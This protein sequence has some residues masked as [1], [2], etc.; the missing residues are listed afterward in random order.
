M[1]KNIAYFADGTWDDPS[2]NTN[3]LQLFEATDSIDGAQAKEYDSGIGADGNPVSHLFG[4]AFGAG[5]TGKIK[6]G[7]TWIAS[8]YLPGDLIYLFGFSRGAYTARCLAGMIAVS[9]LPTVNQ[10]DPKCLD[11]AFEAYRNTDYR[12]EILDE[13]NHSYEMDNAKIHMIGVWDTVGSLGIP[14]I[15]GGV[16]VIQ[17]GFLDTS[18]HPDVQNAVQALAIDEERLQF[19]P[20]L[21]APAQTPGQTLAQV[22]FTGCHCDVGGG[23]GTD[24]NGNALS[25]ITLR[26]M[27]GH[28]SNN[29]LQISA[30][31][32]PQT[33][34]IDDAMAAINNSLIGLYTLTPHR[35][36]IASDASLYVS[37]ADRC[38]NPSA[39]YSPENLHIRAG[40]LSATYSIVTIP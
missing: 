3:V 22:W 6:D 8:Q 12:S 33:P 19:Q 15:F 26:W 5:I 7:Y 37:V 4:G 16:D 23:N 38:G 28:A 17:Y 2:N 32:L 21:W 27:A 29:G 39:N 31:K 25:N 34:L 30:G 13:L 24:K 10:D 40:N 14:A 9:G 20:T 1:P 11:M 35:R 18:L 36:N